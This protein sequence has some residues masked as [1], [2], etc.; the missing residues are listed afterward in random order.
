[1]IET[2]NV[3]FHME[4]LYNS[5][6][7]VSSRAKNIFAGMNESHDVY[8]F[9]SSTNREAQTTESLR[10]VKSLLTHMHYKR[11]R[12]TPFELSLNYIIEN[13][14]K[15]DSDDF[16]F[17]TSFGRAIKSTKNSLD[18][19]LLLVPDTYYTGKEGTISWKQLEEYYC[20]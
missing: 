5:K 6:Q 9:V 13:V 2:P 8:G 7:T 14:A 3:I 15:N 17:I 18:A 1:M 4:A 20:Q 16:T 10:Q 11:G 12:L 19:R